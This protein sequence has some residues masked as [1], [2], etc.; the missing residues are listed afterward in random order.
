MIAS[1]EQRPPL[2]F[3]AGPTA[4]GK[5][6]VALELARMLDAEIVSA[7]A[8]QVYRGMPILT[9][10][11]SEDD[12]REIPH[13]MVGFLDPSENWDAARHCRRAMQ[14]IDDIHARGKS[15][16]VVGGSGLYLKFLTHGISEAPP[17]DPALRE[18]MASRELAD[19]VEELK[20]IDPEGAAMTSLENRRYVERNL[21]IVLLGGKPLSYW[22]ENWKTEPLGVGFVITREPADQE[23]RIARR[24][25]LMF[26][27]GVVEEVKQLGLCSATAE[28][29]LGLSVI[30]EYIAG[31]LDKESCIKKLTLVTRQYAKRQ[32]TWLR[33]EQW[34]QSVSA[35]E[36]SSSFKLATMIKTNLNLGNQNY[37]GE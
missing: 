27:L 29:T 36:N 31:E 25:H 6:G 9:A 18:S 11:P 37:Y 24:S 4:S 8:Y 3:I 15:A 34:M 20:R 21:E 7:D 12:C 1:M 23:N 13:H 22:R 10:A 19:L 35:D 26:D 14:C 30:R 33:R 32:R 28:R 5:S 17:S 16:I 2:I